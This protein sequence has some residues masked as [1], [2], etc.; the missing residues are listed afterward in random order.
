MKG[1]IKG[2]PLFNMMFRQPF[3]SGQADALKTAIEANDYS[4]FKTALDNMSPLK[5][6][7][8]DNFTEFTQAFE[9]MQNKDMAKMQAFWQTYGPKVNE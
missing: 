6:I 5:Y 4:A 8:A 9:A 1:K 3:A 7:T 2:L